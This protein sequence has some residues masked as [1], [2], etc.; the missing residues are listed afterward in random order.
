MV[1]KI[2]ITFLLHLPLT[3]ALATQTE[4]VTAQKTDSSISYYNSALKELH[5]SKLG[6]AKA[7]I[8]RS[9]FLNPLSLSSH[10][11]NSKIT[12]KIAENLGSSRKEEISFSSRLL[13]LIPSSVSYIFLII[14]LIMFFLSL[15]KL[16]FSEKSSYKT[17]PK[18]RLRTTALAF[19]LFLSVLVYASKEVSLATKWACVTSPTSPLYTGPNE[20]TFVQTTSLPQGSCVQVVSTLSNWVS[21]K[22]AHR[23]SGWA[24]RNVLT[25][26]R[27]YKFDPSINKD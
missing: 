5:T 4:T 17:N 21:L 26:V 22:P 8:E 24:N 16:S 18:I 10:K 7:N 23:P 19:V 25:I 15:A 2:L 6:L 20:E 14:A 12:E 1:L 11:L 13:S 3:A 9:L 27:G